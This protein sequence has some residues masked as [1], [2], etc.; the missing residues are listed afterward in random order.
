[1][2]PE[3]EPV[4]GPVHEDARQLVVV[5]AEDWEA[6]PVVVRRFERER[7]GA[8]TEVGEAHAAVIGSAG[9]AWGR[10]LHGDGVPEGQPGPLKREGDRKSPAGVFAIG[11]AFGYDAEPVAGAS[12]P[13]TRA[14]KAW[15][16]VDDAA[17]AHYTRIVD[18]AAVTPDWSSSERM[19]RN[20]EL[21]RWVIVVDHNADAVPGGGSCIF[22]HV[23]SGKDGATVGCT[24]MARD[25]LESLLAWLDPT[26]HPVIVQ[27]PADRYAALRT[28][29]QLP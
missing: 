16:C 29:W 5:V 20:D 25:D 7:G 27:L 13:Y 10:G 17:S 2:T 18:E 21:Y 4:R 8:W 6:V 22:L 12:L 3:P 1:M 19:K 28:A 23:W 24:A 9:L 11:G 26:A 14:T 15:R